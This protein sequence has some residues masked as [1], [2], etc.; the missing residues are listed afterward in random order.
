[1]EQGQSESTRGGRLAF[2][3]A[4]RAMLMPQCHTEHSDPLLR[5]LSRRGRQRTLRLHIHLRRTDT[6]VADDEQSK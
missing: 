3:E 5:K 1:M 2:C 6:P 4:E